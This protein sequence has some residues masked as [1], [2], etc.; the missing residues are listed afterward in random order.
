M[1]S[2]KRIQGYS[3]KQGPPPR[4]FGGL[5]E[6]YIRQ[7]F[8][9]SSPQA[10]DEHA[11]EARKAGKLIDAQGGRHPFDPANIP[12]KADPPDSPSTAS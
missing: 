7:N 12:A 1:T 8:K 4:G 5:N 9:D 6:H 10:I 3:Q 11:Q 2:N